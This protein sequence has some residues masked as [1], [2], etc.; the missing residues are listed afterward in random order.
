MFQKFSYHTKINKHFFS[1]CFFFFCFCFFVFFFFS[2]VDLQC[3]SEWCAW[4]VF[5]MTSASPTGKK[6]GGLTACPLREAFGVVLGCFF[7]HIKKKKVVLI[8]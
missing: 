1:F 2:F 6:S 5:D 4:V 8:L 3:V 7:Y